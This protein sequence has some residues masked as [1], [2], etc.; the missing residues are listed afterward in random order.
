MWNSAIWT[1]A[2]CFVG[3]VCGPLWLT[4]G[5]PMG[6]D[7]SGIKA[8]IVNTKVARRVRAGQTPPHCLIEHIQ[9]TSKQQKR[10]D[11]LQIDTRNADAY[12]LHRFK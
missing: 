5:A 1:Y 8:G 7:K 12:A 2:T 4:G 9:H 3:K 10:V 6:E 11:S